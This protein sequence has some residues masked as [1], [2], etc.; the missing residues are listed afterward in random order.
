MRNDQD[1]IQV[2]L[3]LFGS[4]SLDMERMEQDPNWRTIA[5]QY[6][7]PLEIERAVFEY[8]THYVRREKLL[9]DMPSTN[10]PGDLQL[11]QMEVVHAKQGR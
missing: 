10:G 9:R 5:A 3:L 11:R 1:I 7:L 6:D 8:I 2:D 4:L